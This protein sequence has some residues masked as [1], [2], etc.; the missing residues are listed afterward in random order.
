M[1]TVASTLCHYVNGG[2]G[3]ASVLGGKIGGFYAYL[4]DEIEANVVDQTAIGT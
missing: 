2:A 3:G 1:K 4:L